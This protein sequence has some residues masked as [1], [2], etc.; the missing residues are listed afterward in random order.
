MLKNFK[1]K[2]LI[3]LQSQSI[4]LPILTIDMNYKVVIREIYHILIVHKGLE[5]ARLT[6]TVQKT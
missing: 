2:T 4:L 6:K 3:N 5:C 1:A